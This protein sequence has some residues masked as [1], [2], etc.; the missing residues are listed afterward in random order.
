MIMINGNADEEIRQPEPNGKEPEYK[1][2]LEEAVPVKEEAPSKVAPPKEISPV[3]PS[4]T[5]S[6]TDSS[7]RLL[8]TLSYPIGIIGLILILT[9]KEDK[10]ARYH[11]YNGLFLWLGVA[12]VCVALGIIATILSFVPLVGCLFG[13]VIS[14]LPLCFLIYSIILAVQVNKGEYPVIPIITDLAKQFVEK[15]PF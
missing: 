4:R 9:K 12:V 11:G 6:S 14:V 15:S 5:G 13:L 7:D 8:Y 2:N 3:E 10:D 1:V